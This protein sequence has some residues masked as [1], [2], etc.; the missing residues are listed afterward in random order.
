MR[1]S[2][3]DTG[4]S[5][6]DVLLD[7]GSSAL[8]LLRSEIQ[9]AQSEVRDRLLGA[10]LAGVLFA[11]GAAAALLGALFL[12]L[13]LLFALRLVLPAWAAAGCIAMVLAVTATIAFTTAARRFRASPPL[14]K[15]IE[16]SLEGTKENAAW[17][18]R[19]ATR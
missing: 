6:T 12:L 2:R 11:V 19:P 1:G 16:D 4:R 15:P 3:V 17:P 7:I 13:A 18:K 5:I 10:R 9:L 8:E 14:V